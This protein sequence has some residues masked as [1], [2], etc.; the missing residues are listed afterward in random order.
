MPHLSSRLTPDLE[1]KYRPYQHAV[2]TTIMDRVAENDADM[3]HLQNFWNDVFAG[4]L[5][6]QD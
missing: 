3:K 2:S 5:L 6:L 4:T 1:A